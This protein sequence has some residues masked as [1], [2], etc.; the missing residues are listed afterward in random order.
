MVNPFF[1]KR[2]FRL[3]TV[4]KILQKSR[5]ILDA[6]LGRF[7]KLSENFFHCDLASLLRV[8][9]GLS[10]RFCSQLN[11][12]TMGHSLVLWRRGRLS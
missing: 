7:G 5:Y 2:K 11:I 4:G 3:L 12:Q 8:V 9:S 10:V 1:D 6:E